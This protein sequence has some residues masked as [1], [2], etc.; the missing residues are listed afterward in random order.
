[1]T[2]CKKHEF[3]TLCHKHVYDKGIFLNIG[4]NQQMCGIS[5]PD[6]PEN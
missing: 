4:I 2:Q 6:I 5:I 3:M 1:M